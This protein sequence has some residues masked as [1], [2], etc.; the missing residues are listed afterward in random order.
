MH[1]SGVSHRFGQFV[2]LQNVGFSLSGALLQ[3]FLFSSLQDSMITV[4]HLVFP[5]LPSMYWGLSSA[6]KQ[7]NIK[8]IL[9]K[10][11]ITLQKLNWQTY[12]LISYKGVREKSKV[13]TEY[14][15]YLESFPL[16]HTSKANPSFE[17]QL[18]LLFPVQHFSFPPKTKQALPWVVWGFVE[19]TLCTTQVDFKLYEIKNVLYALL[20]SYG[21]N[22]RVGAS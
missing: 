22:H 17:A 2:Y 3:E 7:T 16:L 20:Y 8:P 12:Q 15:S 14:F 6:D 10:D 5:T 21:D 1:I 11:W 13:H 4:F 18:K 19:Y 9:R